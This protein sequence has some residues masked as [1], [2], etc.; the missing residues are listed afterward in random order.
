MRKRDVLER[1]IEI[2]KRILAILQEINKETKPALITLFIY[3][4]YPGRQFHKSKRAKKQSY[5]SL[6]KINKELRLGL[7]TL[8]ISWF[9]LSQICLKATE[10][11]NGRIVQILKVEVCLPFGSFFGSEK[12]SVSVLLI[13]YPTS[14]VYN[15]LY[16]FRYLKNEECGFQIRVNGL[17]D[18]SRLLYSG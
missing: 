14:R 4:P 11:I 12:D 2:K 10:S 1:L 15:Y 5:L 3:Y 6:Y 13:F 17:A 8:F 7:I 16:L 18:R 9:C